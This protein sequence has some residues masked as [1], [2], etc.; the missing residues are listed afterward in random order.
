MSLAQWADASAC[1]IFFEY[2]TASEALAFADF[3]SKFSIDQL[4]CSSDVEAEFCERDMLSRL[5]QFVDTLPPRLKTIALRHYW[6]D[7]TQSEIAR[8]LGV[9]RSAVC[10]SLRKIAEHG[11]SYFRL[12]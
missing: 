7:E 5:A 8:S 12:N 10:H 2:G 1:A 11:R 4:P 6:G 9:Q 3:P